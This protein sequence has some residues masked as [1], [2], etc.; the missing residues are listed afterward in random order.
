[1]RW[2][3]QIV[4]SVLPRGPF[5]WCDDSCRLAGQP[6]SQ[7]T[8]GMRCPTTFQAKLALS[9]RSP[10]SCVSSG[11][12]NSGSGVGE[13]GCENKKRVACCGIYKEVEWGYSSRRGGR[14]QHRS[15][16]STADT[17]FN[18]VSW[19]VIGR[20]LGSVR[21]WSS[22][23]LLT[24]CGDRCHDVQFLAGPSPTHKF[25]NSTNL[26]FC[27]HRVKWYSSVKSKSPDISCKS[28]DCAVTASKKLWRHSAK[29]SCLFKSLGHAVVNVTLLCQTQWHPHQIQRTNCRRIPYETKRETSTNL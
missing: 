7:P 26:L 18:T 24:P 1:V 6:V 13:H 27:R 17:I 8:I 28:V 12:S 29:L 19:S 5:V 21:I 20:G 10:Y 22:C 11:A 25:R 2:E 9:T 3:G 4:W 16:L 23:H 15:I 14:G